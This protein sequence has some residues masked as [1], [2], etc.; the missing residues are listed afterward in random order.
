MLPLCLQTLLLVQSRAIS[1]HRNHCNSAAAVCTAADEH[2]VVVFVK[3]M[4]YEQQ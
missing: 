2:V 3:I 4:L 1:R